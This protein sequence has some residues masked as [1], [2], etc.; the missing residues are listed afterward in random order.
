MLCLLSF[1]TVSL[2]CLRLRR[3]KTSDEHGHQELDAMRAHGFRHPTAGPSSG[4]RKSEYVHSAQQ[5]IP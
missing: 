1:V 5:R 2:L 4:L 3:L